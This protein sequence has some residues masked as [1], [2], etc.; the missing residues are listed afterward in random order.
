MRDF[1]IYNDELFIIDRQSLRRKTATI[2]NCAVSSRSKQSLLYC[3]PML[4]PFVYS[5]FTPRS[6]QIARG[7]GS[8]ILL[9]HYHIVILFL[10]PP[11]FPPSLLSIFTPFPVELSGCSRLLWPPTRIRPLSWWTV[12]FQWKNP[13]FLIKYPDFLLKRFDFII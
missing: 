6:H 4:T 5:L 13:D 3:S 11:I 9:L 8:P 1:F 12:S 10:H 7:C 2:L